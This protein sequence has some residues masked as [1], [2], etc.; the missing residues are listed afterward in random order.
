MQKGCSLAKPTETLENFYVTTN[1]TIEILSIFH[2]FF[3]FSF[4]LSP[5]L[6]HQKIS[7]GGEGSSF[8]ADHSIG[9]IAFIITLITINVIKY[10]YTLT[11]NTTII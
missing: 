8:H 10:I 9:V 4:D 7:R 1:E 3:H 5:L 6:I 11:N 2:F